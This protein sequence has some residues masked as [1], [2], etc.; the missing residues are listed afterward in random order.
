[1]EV[2][3]EDIKR[4]LGAKHVYLPGS[5]EDEAFRASSSEKVECGASGQ[6]DE[7]VNPLKYT[8][9][10]LISKEGLL[11]SMMPEEELK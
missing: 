4:T 5:K 10:R 7:A 1:M 9:H 11:R 3:L 6:K 8:S 2:I